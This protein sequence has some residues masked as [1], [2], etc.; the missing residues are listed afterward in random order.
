MKIPS[1]EVDNHSKDSPTLVSL[2]I[3]GEMIQ[4][5]TFQDAVIDA[6][7][8]TFQTPGCTGSTYLFS[9]AMIKETYRGTPRGSPLRQLAVDTYA[10][11]GDGSWMED[12][13]DAKDNDIGEYIWKDVTRALLTRRGMPKDNDGPLGDSAKR[14]RYHQHGETEACPL[15]DRA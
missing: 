15:A 12:D 5:K 14:C 2:Y 11:Y 7:Q 4:D 9:S 1:D 6:L 10:F 13:N 3:F 8:N